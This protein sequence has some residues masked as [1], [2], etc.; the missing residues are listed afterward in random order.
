MFGNLTPVDFSNLL[1]E[2]QQKIERKYGY[3][4]V[5]FP[6]IVHVLDALDEIEHDNFLRASNDMI[7]SEEVEAP[8]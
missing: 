6:Y 5:T 1:L 3:A 4:T 2:I 7:P 8:F